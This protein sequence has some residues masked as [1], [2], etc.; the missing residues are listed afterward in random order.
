M[1]CYYREDSLC[2]NDSIRRTLN[3]NTGRVCTVFTETGGRAGEGFTGLVADVN[4]ESCK[5]ITA[6]PS[7]S[8][9]RPF[10][11]GCDDSDD[12]RGCGCG[13]RRRDRGDVLGTSCTIPL[14]KITCVAE[15][16]L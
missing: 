5:I 6:M 4:D 16:T 9:L 11:R 3:R 2:E 14:D 1:A 10:G 12:R 15:S 7:S 13:R 8:E